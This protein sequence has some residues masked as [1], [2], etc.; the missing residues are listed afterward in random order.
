MLTYIYTAHQWFKIFKDLIGE[1]NGCTNVLPEMLLIAS[2]Y[3]AYMEGLQ[4][5]TTY[6]MMFVCGVFPTVWEL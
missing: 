4:F 6:I 2:S 5:Y 1:V 3:Y